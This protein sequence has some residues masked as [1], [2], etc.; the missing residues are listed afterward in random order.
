M[1]LKAQATGTL[2]P[3]ISISAAIEAL[4][5]ARE[6]GATVVNCSFG[7]P[8]D[9]QAMEDEVKELSDAGIPVICAAGNSDQDNDTTPK[10]PA[11]YK[12]RNVISVASS[13]LSDGLS[14][15]SN[16]G[17]YS[18]DYAAPGGEKDDNG[19][20]IEKIFSLSSGGDEDSTDGVGTSYSAP[21]VTGAVALLQA[22]F[23]H[24]EGFEI[25]DRIRFGLDSVSA[26]QNVIW[27]GGRLN[28][29]DAMH[30]R[31][32]LINLSTRA[33]V[34]TG[35]SVTIA[36]FVLRGETNETKEVYVT[37]VGIRSLQNGLTDPQIAIYDGP[38]QIYT[39]NDW[40]TQTDTSLVQRIIDTGI[41]P[42]DSRDAAW[43]GDLT[44]NKAYTVIM[45]GVNNTTGIGLIET[46][47]ASGFADYERMINISTRAWV[48]TGDSVA[49]GGM[50]TPSGDPRR[51]L[52]RGLGPSLP[53]AVGTRISDP[54][55]TLY[56]GQSVVVT[57]DNWRDIDGTGT[58]DNVLEDRIT[59]LGIAPSNDNE[60]VIIA[61]LDPSSAYTVIL[62]DSNGGTGVG[63]VE[64]YEY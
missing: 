5:Y 57:V 10:Y 46:Y 51:V 3:S 32:H 41:P 4:T 35:N 55:L 2:T 52:I 27:D 43:I 34:Q 9:S 8:T 13:T 1:C 20:V 21:L 23:P 15:F 22:Q 64:I 50:I 36:G 19:N 54:T 12:Y 48:G 33:H 56:K 49:I 6:N 39:N 31:P 24:E 37:G 44:V 14:I 18:V 61:T 45:S 11:N 47:E 26:F 40:Q 25:L 59:K 38:T 63:M 58:D 7:S 16:S 62:S 30:N 29:A 42:T 53:S 60:S 17:Q 28:V